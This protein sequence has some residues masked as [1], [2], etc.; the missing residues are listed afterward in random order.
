MELSYNNCIAEKF[1]PFITVMEIFGLNMLETCNCRKKRSK[2][3]Q[4]LFKIYINLLEIFLWTMVLLYT[5]MITFEGFCNHLALVFENNKFYI[6]FIAWWSSLYAAL[7][8]SIFKKRKLNIFHLMKNFKKE[9][10][11]IQKYERYI[12]HCYY[13]CVFILL[14]CFT[15]IWFI[16]YSAFKSAH[17]NYK[18]SL[19]CLF[20]FE[21][22]VLY[23]MS[24]VFCIFVLFLIVFLLLGKRLI[25]ISVQL[26]LVINARKT[27]V[28]ELMDNLWEIWEIFE[29][30]NEKWKM[31]FPLIYTFYV[32]ETCFCIYI[33]LFV[34]I[35]IIF[36]IVLAV[37]GILLLIAS[38]I[39]S[40]ALSYF[41]SIIY[42]NFISIG[43]YNSFFTPEYRFKIICFMKRFGGR[44][45]G[46]SMCGF[47][48]IKKNFLIRCCYIY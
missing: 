35:D 13:F 36:R 44:P 33:V 48:Y 12:F 11:F 15:A 14:C 7:Q 43:R 3:I 26:Q 19:F 32:Y 31:F 27:F 41:T 34:K 40:W 45:F 37:F 46:L 38:L 30:I 21:L 18:M 23:I 6:K 24:H 10:K 39:V 25:N 28:D 5:T 2:R 4:N 16:G 29:E 47:F 8:F 9:E 20:G 42:D 17:Y 22:W 1:Q